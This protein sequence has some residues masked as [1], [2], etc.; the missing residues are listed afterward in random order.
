ML[1]LANHHTTSTRTGRVFKNRQSIR[2]NQ[3]MYKETKAMK[4][5]ERVPNIAGSS[6][7][8]TAPWDCVGAAPTP[9]QYHEVRRT[10]VV[11]PKQTREAVLAT[12][13][14]SAGYWHYR[15]FRNSIGTCYRS[16]QQRTYPSRITYPAV[17]QKE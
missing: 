14:T 16:E 13:L 15:L 10:L 1:H 12:W 3:E 5:K 2:Q 11:I 17:G 6:T 4:P 8:L 7:K 9:G